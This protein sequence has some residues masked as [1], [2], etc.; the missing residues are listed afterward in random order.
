MDFQA[1]LNQKQVE[2]YSTNPKN[3]FLKKKQKKEC[4]KSITNQYNLEELINNSVY[5]IKNTDS[6]YIDYEIIKLFLIDDN[7]SSITDYIMFLIVQ[8]IETH[9]SF[10]MHINLNTLTISGVERYKIFIIDFCNKC[11][12]SKHKII[13]LMKSLFIYNTPNV[14]ENIV[15]LLKPFLNE[16]IHQK[17]IYHSKYDSPL[18]ISQLLNENTV[19]ENT[20]LENT[21]LENM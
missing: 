17:V 2:Y 6:I 16:L 15:R 14:M 20:V 4:A 1:N 9:G 10:N 13:E 11:I 8:N 7:S 5:K 19:L 3:F 21:V 12:S 18:L